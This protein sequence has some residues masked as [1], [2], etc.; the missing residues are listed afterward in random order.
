MPLIVSAPGDD[1]ETYRF[2][3]YLN[4]LEAL[5]IF[6]KAQFRKD[7]S[8]FENIAQS[9]TF[10]K[11][12]SGKCSNLDLVRKT[13]RSAWLTEIQLSLPVRQPE[14][15]PYANLWAPVQ[16]YYCVYLATRAFFHAAGRDVAENHTTTLRTLA[17]EIE[18]RPGI[19]PQPW[20]VTCIGDTE[21][22]G[23][24]Y[25]NLPR[26]IKIS[27]VSSLMS[28][29]RV[30]FWDSFGLFLKT[31]RSRQIKK[32]IK[33]WKKKNKR[34]RIKRDEREQVGESLGPTSI[35]H[36]FYRLRTRSNYE[37]AEAFLVA[38]ERTSEAKRFHSSLRRCAWYTLLAME[39]LISQYVGR[40]CFSTW[41]DEF[42]LNERHGFGSRLC[43]RRRNAIASFLR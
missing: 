22:G 27:P 8:P 12:Q 29:D 6:L 16:L 10:K 28:G 39:L 33:E 30:D 4:Y 23:I 26:G 11:I 35:F 20:R 36:C 32:A 37:D 21:L 9:R 5:D 19:F 31:T 42:K 1:E 40:N 14:L 43:V 25:K 15:V 13:L 18:S 34:R 2:H 38:L 41:V 3:T 24:I 7:W 17:S